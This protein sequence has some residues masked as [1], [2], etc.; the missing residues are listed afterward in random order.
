MPA[1]RQRFRIEIKRANVSL[2]ANDNAESKTVAQNTN[3][4]MCAI[5]RLCRS[6]VVAQERQ[7]AAKTHRAL[8]ASQELGDDL[9]RFLELVVMQVVGCIVD[10]YQL[11]FLDHLGRF[12]IGRPTLG[13]SI[14][15]QH[16]RWDGDLSE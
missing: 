12:F 13:R 2:P 16:D 10:V 8:Q 9:C 15:L 1:R 14:S 3:L 6:K 5:S 7:I 11:A 4:V